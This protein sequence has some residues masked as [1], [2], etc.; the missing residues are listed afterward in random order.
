[1]KKPIAI[2]M[3]LVLVVATS[4]T[5][6]HSAS[7]GVA[8]VQMFS[9]TNTAFASSVTTGSVTVT[10]GNLI[11]CSAEAD[12]VALNGITMTDSK[13]N[14]WTRVKATSS[15]A[16]FDSEVWYAIATVGGASYT[17][18]ATDT[19]GGVDS[20]IICEEWSGAS[21]TPVDVSAAASGITST[22]LNSGATASTAQNNEI[23]IGAGSASGNVTMTAGGTY[24][25]LNKVNT[26][27]STQAFESK[28]VSSTG[29][30]TADM[31]SGT[32]GTW[33]MIVATFKEAAAGGVSDL[34]IDN[35][36]VTIFGDF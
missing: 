34:N 21:A 24:T 31:T 15:A 4:Y 23:V 5:F 14:A 28:I 11:I 22:A 8:R 36:G 20:L 1:M 13:S 9:G 7:A 6:P 17:V 29:A 32:S 25:N 26:T 35:K 2:L 30:Q 18:T 19:G 10:A 27:F 33:N 12:T 16:T 3:T